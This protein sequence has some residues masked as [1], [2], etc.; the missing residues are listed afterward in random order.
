MLNIISP[1]YIHVITGKFDP[2]TKPPD[3]P[4]LELLTATILV[5][6]SVNSAFFRSH[7]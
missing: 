4:H 6:V 5:S 3:H 2:L 1:E 7:M